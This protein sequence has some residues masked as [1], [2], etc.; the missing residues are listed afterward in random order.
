MCFV[1][2]FGPSSESFASPV[3]IAGSLNPKAAEAYWEQEI[4]VPE[5]VHL[6]PKEPA[7]ASGNCTGGSRSNKA[8]RTDLYAPEADRVCTA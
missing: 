5:R 8:P 7:T 2:K 1:S 6:I 3:T 4:T